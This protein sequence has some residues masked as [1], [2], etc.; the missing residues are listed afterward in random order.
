[1]IALNH[2][3]ERDLE[4]Y[5][6]IIDIYLKYVKYTDKSSHFLVYK[7][8]LISLKSTLNEK[9]I[10]EC[11]IYYKELGIKNHTA[12]VFVNAILFYMGS[13]ERDYDKC[14]GLKTKAIKLIR[15]L[16]RNEN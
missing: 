10:N 16:N 4:F 13:P 7:S 11:N 8:I 14:K 5:I 15:Q 1:M 12:I 2:L 6:K 9:I 3:T